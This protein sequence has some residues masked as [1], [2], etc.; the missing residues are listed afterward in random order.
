MVDVN[1]EP[2]EDAGKRQLQP[3]I[4]GVD[5]AP[6]YSYALIEQ[7]RRTFYAATHRSQDPT[8]FFDAVDT[9][10]EALAPFAATSENYTQ[11]MKKIK[12]EYEEKLKA[13]KTQD[14]VVS[15]KLDFYRKKLIRL[16]MLY[17]EAGFLPYALVEIWV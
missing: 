8:T 14:Q 4:V 10:E 12:E 6:D 5:R 17:A 1:V 9:L 16:M 3:E 15:V 7:I 2:G 13:A 11:G